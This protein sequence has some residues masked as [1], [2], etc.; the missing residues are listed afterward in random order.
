MFRGRCT[1]WPNSKIPPK[2]KFKK[3]RETDA[4]ILMPATVWQFFNIKLTQWPETEI[5]Y[6]CHL[7][8]SAWKNAWTDP[9]EPCKTLLHLLA[10]FYTESCVLTTLLELVMLLIAVSGSVECVGC[11]S[12]ATDDFL[13]LFSKKIEQIF[14]N[15]LKKLWN[16]RV[17]HKHS[18]KCVLQRKWKSIHVSNLK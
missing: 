17:L 13:I 2:I 5:M 3:S 12:E 10:Q 4:I 9:A 7:L 15:F 1:I 8:K 11:A 6:P 14:Y 16:R 18:Q